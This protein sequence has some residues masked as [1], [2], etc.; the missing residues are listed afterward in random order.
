MG[1]ESR[2]ILRSSHNDTPQKNT[3]DRGTTVEYDEHRMPSTH[4]I[5]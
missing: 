1:M 5:P 3:L 2:E 4:L